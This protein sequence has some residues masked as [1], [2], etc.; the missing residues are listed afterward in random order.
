MPPL[1]PREARVTLFSLDTNELGKVEWRGALRAE[2]CLRDILV[3]A[4]RARL[5]ERRRALVTKPRPRGIVGPALRAAHG[6]PPGEQA[7]EP[8][9]SPAVRKG[10]ETLLPVRYYTELNRGADYSAP[11][12]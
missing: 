7:F 11:V 4:L 2:L 6:L 8:L 1:P 12:C 9:L 3:R 5:A 10:Q